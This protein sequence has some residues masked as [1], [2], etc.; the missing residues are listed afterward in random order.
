MKYYVAILET[1]DSDKDKLI[2]QQ[3]LDYLDELISKGKIFGKG[4]FTDG[5]G[6]MIIFLADSL[7]EAEVLIKNDPVIIENTR[8]YRLKEWNKTY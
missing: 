6:G 4:P 8:S 3:H 1:L 2:R 7:E 5:S